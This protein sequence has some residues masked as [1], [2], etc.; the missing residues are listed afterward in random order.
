MVRHWMQP[1]AARP[2]DGN[3]HGQAGSRPGGRETQGFRSYASTSWLGA[4][5]KLAM[6]MINRLFD[7]AE[8]F[9]N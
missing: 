6:C 9:V 7:T 8:R 1:T 2:K 3:L 4:E 5:T